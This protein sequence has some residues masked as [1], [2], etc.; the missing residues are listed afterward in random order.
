VLNTD[1]S[2]YGGK[3]RLKKGEFMTFP[4]I[5]D[6]WCNRPN[7]IKLYIPCRTAI[8]LIPIE[9]LKLHEE[10]WT[11]EAKKTEISKK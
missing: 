10:R 8:V 9:K 11:Q 4:Y 3:D 2:E 7:H 5:L 6:A 1:R